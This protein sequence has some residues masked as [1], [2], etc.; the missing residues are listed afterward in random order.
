[1]S[2][3]NFALIPENPQKFID[4]SLQ[5]SQK[6]KQMGDYQLHRNAIPHVTLCHFETTENQ[7]ETVWNKLKKPGRSSLFSLTFPILD[8]C[9]H[10]KKYWYLLIPTET[11]LLTE[12]H[13]DSLITLKVRPNK[14]YYPHLTLFNIL[15]LSKKDAKQALQPPLQ[16]HFFFAITDRD[17]VGQSKNILIK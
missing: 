10:Q 6:E 7:L 11:D 17:D 15:D 1:M 2:K 14:N 13:L 8:S 5:L 16:D 3:Y 9:L 12:L 4:F